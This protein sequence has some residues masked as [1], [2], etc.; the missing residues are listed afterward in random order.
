M[1]ST[2]DS[3]FTRRMFLHRGMTLASLTA[4]VPAFIE[5]SAFGMVHP[6]DSLLSSM[7]EA[8]RRWLFVGGVAL[9]ML[10]I[11]TATFLLVR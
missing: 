11:I 3:T 1:T 6:L 7:P 2:N 4:T 5:R 10:V 9:V 8:S